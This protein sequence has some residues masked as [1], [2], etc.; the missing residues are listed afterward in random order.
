[1]KKSLFYFLFIIIFM[2]ILSLNVFADSSWH[3][4]TDIHPRVIFPIAVIAT[5]LCEFFGV[6]LICKIKKWWK[7]FLIIIVANL[8]SF[9]FPCL[10]F[11]IFSP[12]GDFASSIKA[13]DSNYPSYIIEPFYL[14]L[15]LIIEVPI[16]YFTLKNECTN[17]KKLLITVIAVNIF[18]TA[19]IAIIERIFCVGS[20]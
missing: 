9:L 2:Q 11:V 15:T 6:T 18:T 13:F 7:V 1:M 16:V 4:I 8:A 5:L 12:Y 10:F 17:R 19:M 3:W 14:F 20:W